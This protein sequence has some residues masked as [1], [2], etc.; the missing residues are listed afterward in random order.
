M[1]A[2]SRRSFAPYGMPCSGPRSFPRRSSASARRACASASWRVSA[3]RA[4]YVGPCL[5]SRSRSA[6]VSSSEETERRR[7]RRPSVGMSAKNGSASTGATIRAPGRRRAARMS[8][9]LLVEDGILRGLRDAELDDALRRD[10]DRFTGPWIAPHARLAV[11]EYELADAG[12]RETVLRFLVG[13]LRDR[14]ERANRVLAA[15]ADLGREMRCDRR[16]R[17]E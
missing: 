15:H 7:R 16:L 9:L 3:A 2:V 6:R 5:A 4:L 10:L 13:E 11:H 17:S 1:P 14:F 12:E 8:A